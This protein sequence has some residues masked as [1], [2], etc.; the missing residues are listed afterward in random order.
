MP[1]SVTVTPYPPPAFHPAGAAAVDHRR[2]HLKTQ[3]SYRAW[4]KRRVMQMDWNYQS[5]RWAGAAAVDH[6]RNYPRP[7]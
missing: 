3:R 5:Y 2:T 6:R 7:A 4:V 1:V